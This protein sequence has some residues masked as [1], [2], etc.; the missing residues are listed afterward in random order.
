MTEY[1]FKISADDVGVDL[2][3]PEIS[4]AHGDNAP[5]K[6]AYLSAALVSIFINDISKHIKENP[7]GFIV[8]AQTMINNAEFLKGKAN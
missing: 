4:L 7:K 2:E 3:A 1:I 6:I 8:S 5:Q